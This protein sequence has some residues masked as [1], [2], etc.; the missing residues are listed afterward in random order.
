[1][2]AVRRLLSNYQQLNSSVGE[3]ATETM[4]ADSHAM[5]GGSSRHAYRRVLRQLRHLA[6]Q[7][8]ALA[9]TIKQQLTAAATSGRAPN[10]G[11]RRS[12][13]QRAQALIYQAYRLALHS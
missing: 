13:I 9:T 7:R 12:E 3:F 4:I 11:T 5:A 8:D 10:A 2:R 6:D 1:L